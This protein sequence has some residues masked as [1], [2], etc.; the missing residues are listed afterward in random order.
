MLR[1]DFSKDQPFVLAIYGCQFHGPSPSNPKSALIENFTSLLDGPAVHIEVM[2]N[3]DLSVVG[4]TSRV[5][6]T[7]WKSPKEY[8]A[9]WQSA[10]VTAFWSALPDDAG[11]WREKLQFPATRVLFETNQRVPNGFSHAGSFQPLTEKTGY[12]GSYRDRIEESTPEDKLSSPVTTILPPPKMSRTIRSGRVVMDTF[13]DHLCCVVE[14]QDHS[15]MG[16]KEHEYWMQHFNDL[17]NNWIT[18]TVTTGNVDGVVSA[19]LCHYPDRGLINPNHGID[20][21]NKW[22]P[23]LGYNRKLQIFYF[24]DMSYMEKIGRKYKTHIDLRRNFMK[25]YGPAGD[26]EGGDLL[27]W[28]DLGVL[29]ANEMEAE[30]VGCYEGTG[31]M[32]YLDHPAFQKGGLTCT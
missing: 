3:D 21:T 17:S 22:A 16:P 18:T 10:L 20:T 23:A 19:R 12:W 30:Y 6:M 1:A 11:F 4:G 2:D 24:L 13:P 27:L 9:W 31:F 25:A 26:M 5:W 32:G 15:A 14:G 7:Y 8:E 29:K 28:V